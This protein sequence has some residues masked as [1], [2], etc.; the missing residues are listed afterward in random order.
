MEV[1]TRNTVH[2]RSTGYTLPLT[3]TTNAES[4]LLG[5]NCMS[6]LVTF[7]TTESAGFQPQRGPLATTKQGVR[8]R[9]QLHVYASVASHKTVCDAANNGLAHG[10]SL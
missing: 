9:K 4:R 6:K 10:R 3:L 5:D 7:Y 1:E 2:L 8:L